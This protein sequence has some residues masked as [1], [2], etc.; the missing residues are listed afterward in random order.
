MSWSI[1]QLFVVQA[2]GTQ[3]CPR[4]HWWIFRYSLKQV[5][6]ALLLTEPGMVKLSPLGVYCGNI[7]F[8]ALS[9]KN[10]GAI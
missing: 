1:Q 2:Q 6:K 9:R 8:K 5:L 10:Y 3:K 4:V 7:H